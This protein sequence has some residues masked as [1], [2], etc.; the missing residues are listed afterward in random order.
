VW[1]GEG[2]RREDGIDSP[3]RRPALTA[4]G[5]W[6]KIDGNWGWESRGTYI[7]S[8]K[9]ELEWERGRRGGE[10]KESG[11]AGKGQIAR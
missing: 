11:R 3:C 8:E 6:F 9:W 7:A 2:R 1:G 4:S 5:P 10:E